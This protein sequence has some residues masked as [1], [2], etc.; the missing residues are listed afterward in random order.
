[1]IIQQAYS[2]GEAKEWMRNRAGV[3]EVVEET[4]E[5]IAARWNLYKLN[6]V[7]PQLE[8]AWFC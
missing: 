7:Y 8:S 3:V 6:S 4:A 1:V 5:M 2:A